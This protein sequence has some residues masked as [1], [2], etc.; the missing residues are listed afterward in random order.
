MRTIYAI[1]LIIALV[2]C[3]K[4]NCEK[5]TR[6]WTFTSVKKSSPTGINMT[7]PITYSETETFTACGSADIKAA[8]SQVTSHSE[9]SAGD[10]NR[11]A[12]VI[13]VDGSATCDCK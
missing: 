6:T 1:F 8:E 11:P 4:N 12:A 13:V 2:G 5:C 9:Q 3:D 7:T 10:A